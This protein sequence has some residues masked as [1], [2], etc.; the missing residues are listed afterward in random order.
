M[1]LGGHYLN[2]NG[3]SV[4]TLIDLVPR[5][6]GG[7]E[8]YCL[9]MSEALARKGWR[10][11]L[12]FKAPPPAWLDQRYRAAGAAVEQIDMYGPKDERLQRLGEVVRLHR[13]DIFHATFLPIFSFDTIRIKRLGIRKLIYSD[14]A[15][16]VPVRH[17]WLG[18]RAARAKNRLM[19]RWIDRIV[20][21]AEFVSSELTGKSW[22][23]RRKIEVIYNGVNVQRFDRS[24]APSLDRRALGIPTD[25]P[26]V[27]T[28]ANCIPEKGLDVFLKAAQVVLKDGTEA[29]FVIVGDGP[30]L[31]EL[32]QLAQSL[33][34]AES[35]VFL[36]VRSDV[37]E[38]MALSDVF[39]LC[40]LWEEAFALVLLEAMA[41]GLPVV[42][43]RIGAIPESVV[44]GTTGILFPP[45][46]FRAAAGAIARLLGDD[47]LRQQMGTAGRGRVEERF[48]LE[49]WV[50]NTIDLYERVLSE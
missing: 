10:S 27:A 13:V 31:E 40:S 46:D 2:A 11:V 8:E 14:Q 32:R 16:R 36:G 7:F 3:I 26:M 35:T 48:T 23:D 34:I 33:G 37:H 6:F 29:T 15:S 43:S 12:G 17:S 49:H 30:L 21:D 41:S 18:G 1:A 4:L 20:A 5:K 47:G 9:A 25:R 28:V 39:V 19:C 38:I 22:A 24:K 50:N 45:G 44:D 42:A